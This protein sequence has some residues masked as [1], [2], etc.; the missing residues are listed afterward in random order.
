LSVK[1]SFKPEDGG[2]MFH[3]NVGWH[4]TNCTAS[5]PGTWYSS[6]D[7]MGGRVFRKEAL[8]LSGA[9]HTPVVWSR[10]RAEFEKIR[11]HSSAACCF[12]P[13]NWSNELYVTIRSPEQRCTPE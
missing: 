13:Y 11:L 12:A 1:F 3:P 9:G 5:Y 4:S 6:R 10:K 8:K 7:G 2:N